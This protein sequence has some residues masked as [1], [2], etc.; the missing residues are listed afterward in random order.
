MENVFGCFC[1]KTEN[2]LSGFCRKTENVGALRREKSEFRD[3]MKT[4]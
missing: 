3:E 2:V 4:A 1:C